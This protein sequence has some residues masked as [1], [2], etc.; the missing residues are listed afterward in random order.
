M[1]ATVS[2]YLNS[3]Q[4]RQ[5]GPT[6]GDGM[7]SSISVAL[8]INLSSLV[9]YRSV[10]MGGKK[11]SSL[12]ALLAIVLRPCTSTALTKEECSDRSATA[13]CTTS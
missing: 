10:R 1:F 8:E 12:I 6:K 13:H 11:P 7:W 9:R 2:F 4:G 3:K 5:F